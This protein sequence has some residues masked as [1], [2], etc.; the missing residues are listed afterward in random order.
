MKLS[1]VTRFTM[2]HIYSG[3]FQMETRIFKLNT[4]G[5]LEHNSQVD[6]V[7]RYPPDDA[8]IWVDI[9]RTGSDDLKTFLTEL[10]LHP[11]AVKACL[12][13]L[14]KCRF[15]A[16][17]QSLFIG[18][19]LLIS[20]DDRDRTFLSVLCLPRMLITIHETKIP[21]LDSIVEQFRASMRFHTV[22][23]SAVLYQNLDLIIDQ[24]LVFTQ[25][26]R[27]EIEHL[28]EEIDQELDLN[29]T[30]KA[31]MLKRRILLLEAVLEDQHYCLSALQSVES[32]S[33]SIDGLQDYFR[34]SLSHL[35]HAV[36]SVGRQIDR[37][38]SIHQLRQLKLQDKTNK[39]L[40]ILTVVSAIF[41]PLMLVT[42]IYGMNFQHM[43][44]LSWPYGYFVTI[45][46]M[47]VIGLIMLWYFYR[48]DWFN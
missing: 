44:E 38:S 21:V 13:V 11:L 47:L 19:P 1:L 4:E 23:T 10:K 40:Q 25:E 30:E 14:P 15:G 35:D 8:K 24:H 16:Y 9:R 45:F 12:E 20:C 29:I 37:L 46:L 6:I 28:E 42:G 36:R 48:N 41:M 2:Q 3:K 34:D 27:A 7:K 18:L 43:P 33:F 26:I 17:G 31:Q 39:R 32:K 5:F 22:S